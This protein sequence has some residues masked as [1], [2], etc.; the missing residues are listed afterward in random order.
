[1]SAVSA[2]SYALKEKPFIE[3]ILEEPADG[4]PA[5]F[6]ASRVTYDPRSKQA[7]ATGAVQIVYGPYVLNATRVTY[8]EGTGVF[9][10]DGSVAL[11]EPRGNVMEAET[12]TLFN[13]FKEGFARHVKAL[14]TN[15]VT[16]K[17]RY[18][19]RHADGITIFENASYTACTDC[20]VQGGVPLWELVSDQTTHDQ[21][22]KMLYHVKPRL[23]IAGHTVI[24]LPY[25]AHP[26]PSVKRKTG[27]LQPHFKGTRAIGVGV[28]TPYF[29]AL[30]PNY[31]L[32]ARP[33]ITTRQGVVA[34]LEWR[35]RLANGTYTLRG[36]GLYELGP[37]WTDHTEDRWRGAVKSTGLFNLD[38]NDVWTLSWD[39]TLTSDKH[40]LDDYDYDNSD[41]IGSEVA[42]TGLKDRNYVSAKALHFE[43][44]SDDVDNDYLPTALPYI[45]GEQYLS[46]NVFGGDLSLNWSAYSISRDDPNTPFKDVN[47]GT[48]QTRAQAELRWRSQFISDGG[49]V[50]SPFGRVRGDL[51]LTENLPDPSVPGDEQESETVSRIL[52][53]AG[54]DF[55]YPMIADHSFGQSV[56]SP[57]AQ[58]IAATD[59][60]ETDKIGNED[61]ITVNFDHTSLFLEDRFTGYDRFEGG[62][63]ANVGMTYSLF[64]ADG[65]FVRASLGESFHIAGENSFASGSG[66]EGSQSDLVAAVLVQ[67]MESLSLSYEIRA[68]ED[69]SAINRQEALLSLTFDRFS[70]N[71]GYL[72]IAPEPSAGRNVEEEWIEADARVGLANGWSLFGGA[73]YDLE[74][75]NLDKHTIG[76]EFDRDC[77]NFKLS[78][79]AERA[80]DET[81]TDHRIMMSIDF[82]TLGGTSVTAKF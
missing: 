37:Q 70:G 73:R 33:L 30:A 24:G 13:K 48:E 47:H 45:T 23:K 4:T 22:E 74:N 38:S 81:E 55:R 56:L 15:D 51:Y 2:P 18:A 10:A 75:S 53:A 39:G 27:W 34:D 67:P 20:D 54:V 11:R 44:G 35:H 64:G 3:P 19:E 57:V 71:I 5:D 66:L 9:E 58:I 63:R 46:G 50:M 52:P 32:T 61:S 76:L 8:N 7:I 80:A 69:L 60:T 36:M 59:E 17:S 1:M 28:E 72:N 21:N 40:F 43:S 6:S 77:M 16:I 12:F 41:I 62:V 31:D 68:E 25:F 82:A 26:D 14:L 78:Y 29:W 49:L 65:G 79:S 42:L